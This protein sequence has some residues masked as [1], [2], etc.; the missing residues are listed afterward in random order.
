[1]SKA[2]RSRSVS[3]Q[4]RTVTLS[5]CL[6][7]DQAR[8]TIK[9]TLLMHSSPPNPDAPPNPTPL[10]YSLNS[11]P[12]RPGTPMINFC[13][14][15]FARRRLADAITYGKALVSPSN[16]KLASYD[17]RALTFLVSWI[18]SLHSTHLAY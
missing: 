18:K 11:D 15:F 8:I 2:V 16:L 12:N 13:A 17:N 9:M 6:S 3:T 10:A 5:F 1:M 4:V 7:V 14:G